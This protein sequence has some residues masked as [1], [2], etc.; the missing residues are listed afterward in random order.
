MAETGSET[1]GKKPGRR[2]RFF[3]ESYTRADQMLFAGGIALSAMCAFFPWYV[4]N[5]Q[6]Q[7][8]IRAV[9]LSD[10]PSRGTP[11]SGAIPASRVGDAAETANGNPGRDELDMISTAT[12]NELDRARD[13]SGAG[14]QPFPAP[15]VKYSVIHIANGRAMVEDD[16]GIFVVQRG[17]ILPDSSRVSSIEQRSEGWVVVTTNGDVLAPGG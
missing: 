3:S 16:G 9:K 13:L 5:N 7:F 17:S 10:I 11:P 8:G 12:V 2:Y 15:V 14:E 4:F 6:D 1:T